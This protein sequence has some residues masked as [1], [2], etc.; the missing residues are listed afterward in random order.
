MVGHG[1][2]SYGTHRASVLD[3]SQPTSPTHASGRDSAL[4]DSVIGAPFFQWLTVK[5]LRVQGSSLHSAVCPSIS[6]QH[7]R[8]CCPVLLEPFLFCLG[9]LS[10][11][12][13][14]WSWPSLGCLP[15]AISLGRILILLGHLAFAVAGTG[16]SFTLAT[17]P[18]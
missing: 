3:H 17:V 13:A 8:R 11:Q 7:S 18:L 4:G 1:Q 15:I 12:Q 2:P 6:L 5:G 9:E 10:S 16:P 14:L